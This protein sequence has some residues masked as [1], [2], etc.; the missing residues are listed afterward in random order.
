MS[1]V[2]DT[3]LST[4]LQAI[5]K[6][7]VL[8]R[9][10]KALRDDARPLTTHQDRTLYALMPVCSSRAPLPAFDTIKTQPPLSS[11]NLQLKRK[12]SETHIEGIPV[13]LLASLSLREHALDALPISQRRAVHRRGIGTPMDLQAESSET[14]VSAC[15]RATLTVIQSSVATDDDITESDDDDNDLQIIM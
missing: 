2:V 10:I 14:N 15:A 7:Q 13:A 12:R 1:A 5:Q 9:V 4:I 11:E 8:L 3:E 6:P